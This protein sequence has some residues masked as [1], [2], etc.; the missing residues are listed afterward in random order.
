MIEIEKALELIAAC[1]NPLDSVETPLGEAVGQILSDDLYATIDSPPYD[2]SMMDGY[3]FRAADVAVQEHPSR[4]RLEIVERVFAGKV[5]Q[6]EIKAGT[7]AQIMTG[8]MIPPSA[9]T[10]VVV[11]RATESQFAGRDFVEFDCN[12]YNLGQN[13]LKQGTVFRKGG[14]LISAGESIRPHDVGVLAENGFDRCPV[15]RRPN[16]AVLTTGDE[17]VPHEFE[18]Q[19]G[20]IRDS[21]SPLIAAL[22]QAAGCHVELLGIARDEQSELNHAIR[23]GLSSDLLILSGGVSAGAADLVPNAL[24]TNG[25]VEVFHKVAVKPGKPIWFG[26]HDNAEHRC[27]VFGLPGNPASSLVGFTILARSAIQRMKGSCSAFPNYQQ[28]KLTQ[29][30]VLKGDRVTFWPVLSTVANSSLECTPLPWRGSADIFA[31]TKANGLAR[32]VPRES[33]Y[34][35]GDTVDVLNL[36]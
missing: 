19:N 13:I 34:E 5:P 2:K 10:V 1:A 32:F 6:H 33:S 30:F 31:I 22:A 18:P 35:V 12:A 20:Q 15:F 11:E 3:V 29:Q 8:A 28:A 17:L 14:L 25:V 36:N 9:D 21:N 7:A 4:L 23:R 24:A 27:L 26:Y 16:V